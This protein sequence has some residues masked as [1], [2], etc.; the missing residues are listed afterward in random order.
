MNIRKAVPEDVGPILDLIR[1]R[2]RWMDEIGLDHWNRVDYFG[3]YPER[4][5]EENIASFLVAEQAGRLIGALAL[6]DHDSVWNDRTPARYVHNFV[7][8]ID[9]PGTGAALL[10]FAEQMTLTRGIRL[11]RMDTNLKDHKLSEYYEE[12]GYRTRGIVHRGLFLGVKR[13]KRLDRENPPY[14][15]GGFF[16]SAGLTDGELQLVLEKTSPAD[17]LR[18]RVPAYHFAICGSGGKKMGSCSLRIGHAETLYYAGHIGYE[19]EE[20]FRGRRLAA[21]ACRLLFPLAEKHRL[22]YVLITCDPA[23]PASRRSA[24]LAGCEFL[25]TAP[26]PAWHDLAKQGFTEVCIYGKS[27]TAVRPDAPMRA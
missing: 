20:P 6:Y 16:D 22:G 7:A 5:Y 25:E 12:K 24:E 18:G 9:C 10:R 2:I 13:E 1:R 4:Y 14:D 3:I 27:L 8:D 11:M 23:N 17:P 15:A 26:L 19:V 21:R